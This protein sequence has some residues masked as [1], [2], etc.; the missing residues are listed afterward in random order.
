M[1]TPTAA[2]NAKRPLSGTMGSEEKTRKAPRLGCFVATIPVPVRCCGGSS[3]IGSGSSSS[4]G[5]SSI[6]G[7]GSSRIGGGGGGSSNGSNNGD[8]RINQLLQQLQNNVSALKAIDPATFTDHQQMLLETAEK[9]LVLCC[10]R[11]EEQLDA[12]RNPPPEEVPISFDH[13]VLALS[14]LPARDLAAAAATS[15]HFARAIPEAVRLRLDTLAGGYFEIRY[16]DKYNTELLQR[17]EDDYARLPSVLAKLSKSTPEKV[18]EKQ[19]K[20][21]MED[22]HHEIYYL[23]ADLLWAKL[24]E[25][26]GLSKMHT[27]RGDLVRWIATGRP[28]AEE[29]GKHAELLVGEFQPNGG[30][31]NF[32]A[33]MLME[34]LPPPVIEEHLPV[35]CW[36][37]EE[38]HSALHGSSRTHT[39]YASSALAAVRKVTS[40]EALEKHGVREAVRPLVTS[41][42]RQLREAAK[43][44]L[45]GIG[46]GQVVACAFKRM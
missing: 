7:G 23:H 39:H 20:E 41:A 46:D 37:L 32:R 36:W 9:E 19:V 1:S 13:L 34:E 43:E 25:L 22:L 45:R 24:R 6:S 33:L 14:T 3:S 44:F 2:S 4:G 30:G 17:V 40:I 31:V 15:R 29:L 21:P 35:L 10:D 16:K 8:A 42:D 26:Q 12:R 28:P 11:V 27:R 18:Y 38:E 5:G